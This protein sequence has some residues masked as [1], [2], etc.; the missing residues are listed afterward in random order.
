[1]IQLA[2][3]S[4][5]ACLRHSVTSLASAAVVRAIEAAVGVSP[6]LAA[7]T[8]YLS[9][10]SPSLQDRWNPPSVSSY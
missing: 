3:E 4:A 1:M 7:L 8:R 2:T 10:L 6:A 9:P 5:L